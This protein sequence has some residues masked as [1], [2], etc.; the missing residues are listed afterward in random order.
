MN[1]IYFHIIAI[2][3]VTFQVSAESIQPASPFAVTNEAAFFNLLDY[4]RPELAPVQKALTGGDWTAAKAAWA[5]NLAERKIPQWL[6]SRRDRP[7]F[8][9]IYA[10]YFGGLA[11][12]TN[13]A[14]QVLARKF[15]FMGVP[16]QLAHH[17][18]W[19]QGPLE[20]TH[21][22]SR[23]GYWHELGLAYWGT[24]RGVYAQDFVD[25]LEDWVKSNPVPV[26]PT[27]KLGLH[28]SVWRTLETGIRGQSWF[29]T[30]ELFMD[31]PQFDAEAK[32]LMTR[33]LVEQAR[34]LNAYSTAFQHGNWQVSEASGLATI[35][36]MLPELKEA[37]NWRERGLHLL[38]QHMQ[39]DVLPDGAHWEMTPGYHTWVMNEFMDVSLLCQT[40]GVKTTSM[41]SR[42]EKMFDFLESISRPDR[43]LPAI[44][45]AG[46]S[47]IGE[48]MGRGALMYQQADFRYLAETNWN[49]ELLWLFGADA[50]NKFAAL[51]SRPPSFN[52]VLLPDCKYMVM[53]TGWNRDDK[54][55]LF[56]CAPWHSG[57]NHNDRLQVSV[58]AS[59]DLIVDSGQCSYDQPLSRELRQSA[60][61]NVVLIDGQE[62]L[63][64]DPEL[65]AW[66]TDNQADF[67]CAR[68]VK[69]GI[70][71]LRRVLFVKPGY[72][73]VVDH[74]FGQGEHQVTRLFHFPIGPAEMHG[75]AAHTA[76]PSGMNIWVQP[77]DNAQLKMNTGL[78]PIGPVKTKEAWVATLTSHSR[79]PLTLCTVLLPYADAKELP[80]FSS[81]PSDAD[82]ASKIYLEFP[83]GQRDEIMI[84][85]KDAPLTLG[86]HQ[87]NTRALCVRQGT[88]ANTIITIPPGI[89]PNKMTENTKP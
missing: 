85:Y 69:N 28:G 43:T 10:A 63:K 57:H 3:L 76:F 35:G 4:S 59:R 6:W 74:I 73:V 87:A 86:T 29:E 2:V 64:A 56:Q 11:R 49:A 84:G 83:N 53:R 82:L 32:Y 33:S 60:A 16:K 44:G 72:W 80:K 55:L 62:Q 54:Y 47:K 34:Y 7:K 89:G 12:Y 5:R 77:M 65:L 25:L 52:S 78:I 19:L 22:L 13:A 9:E 37:A 66:H 38:A 41:L 15:N 61:H 42:H 30:M 23:F 40:N 48:S 68:I 81:L 51:P 79:L 39:E 67:A 18:E 70:S 45:D 27:N 71:Q 88:L 17:P 75:N 36:I 20:W 26:K 14:N 1:Q 31:A 50:G 21:V 8:E 46:N 58:F 24:S